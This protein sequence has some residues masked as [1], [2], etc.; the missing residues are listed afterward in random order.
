MTRFTTLLAALAAALALAAP[1]TASELSPDE[2]LARYQPVTVLDRFEAFAPVAIDGFLADSALEERQP[3]GTYAA[4]DWTPDDRPG[5][6]VRDP[7]GCTSAPGAPC[8]RLNQRTCTPAGPVG[9][10]RCYAAA[11]PTTS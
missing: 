10:L 7:S 1:A 9:S 6:P 2:L 4:T 5:L 11:S 3:D 8:L